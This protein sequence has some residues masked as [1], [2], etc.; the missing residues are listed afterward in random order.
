[1]RNRPD[2]TQHEARLEKMSIPAWTTWPSFPKPVCPKQ[3]SRIT[4]MP[5]RVSNY[6]H[7]SLY[8]I[9]GH[10]RQQVVA[11]IQD[12]IWNLCVSIFI[13]LYYCPG[14]QYVQ[15]IKDMTEF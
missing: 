15:V 3:N 7:N 12:N 2:P 1:M 14:L 9:T 5:S 10:M 8:T 11:E 4:L 6:F 13:D